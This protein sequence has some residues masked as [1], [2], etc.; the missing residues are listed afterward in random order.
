MRVDLDRRAPHLRGGR[1]SAREGQGELAGEIERLSKEVERA[2]DA[3]NERF[4]ANAAPEVVEA[5]KDKLQQ[6][7]AEL[8][9]LGG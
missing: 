9:A 4:V 7:R 2:A 5:E 1:P 8:D 3:G 6:Y